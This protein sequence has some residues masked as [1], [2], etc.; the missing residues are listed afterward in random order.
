VYKYT[1][2]PGE[3]RAK[4]GNSPGK[5]EEREKKRKKRK[6]KRPPAML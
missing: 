6:G 3:V 2:D 4:A 5:K 1:G